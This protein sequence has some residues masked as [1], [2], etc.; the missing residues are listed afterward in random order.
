MTITFEKHC[1]HFKFL[2]LQSMTASSSFIVFQIIYI[3]PHAPIITDKFPELW[4][5]MI[6]LKIGQQAGHLAHMDLVSSYN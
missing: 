4:A 5:L 2:P 1:L 3:L 6:S